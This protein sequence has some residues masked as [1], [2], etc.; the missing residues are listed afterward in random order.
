[1][2]KISNGKIIRLEKSDLT[3]LPVDAIVF[4]A[5]EDLELGTGFGSAIQSRGGNAV[6]EELARIG[7]IAMG[8]AAITSAGNM[9]PRH[10][11]HACG[12]KFQEPDREARLRRAIHSALEVAA[13]KGLSTVAFP[14]MGAGFYGVPLDLC[15]TVMLDVISRF[16]ARPGSV[17]EVVVCVVDNREFRAFL[18]KLEALPGDR[19]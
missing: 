5:R 10:I 14:A 12:P 3:A 17:S 9:A 4:Y 2:V 6:K 1:M 7:R 11:I 13:A 8:E 15:A 16:L 18:P 19:S